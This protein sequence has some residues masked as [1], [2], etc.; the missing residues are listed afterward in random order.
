VN[1]V[2]LEFCGIFVFFWDGST[3]GADADLGFG[4]WKR[5]LDLENNKKGL[6]TRL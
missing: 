6:E 5:N 3:S 1:S 2:D 4:E